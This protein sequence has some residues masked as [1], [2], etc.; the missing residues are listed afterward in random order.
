MV[1]AEGDIERRVAEPGALGIEQHRAGRPEQDV[2][3]A[4]VAVHDR[5]VRGGGPVG[6]GGKPV[7]EIGVGPRRDAQVGVDPE[8]VEVLVGGERHRATGVGSARRVQVTDELPD[9][10]CRL[11]IDVA[12]EKERLP[13]RVAAR[14]QVLHREQARCFVVC[15]HPWH[16]SGPDP[17]REL[18]PLVLDVV[19]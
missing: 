19:A 8:R 2:L 1:E 13:H 14:C 12:G 5:Q 18:Q 7:L 15:E 17:L 9:C 3:W 16:L 4:H 6:E 11:H 10:L